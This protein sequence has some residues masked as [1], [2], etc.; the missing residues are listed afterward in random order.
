MKKILLGT[1]LLVII[2]SCSDKNKT[3][4]Q[5]KTP[6]IEKT[7]IELEDESI[8]KGGSSDTTT[9]DFVLG[10]TKQQV[11]EHC[12]KLNKKK[13]IGFYTDGKIYCPLRTENFKTL[14]SIDFYYDNE[15]KL[16]RVVEQVP[17]E[18]NEKTGENSTKANYKEE[19]LKYFRG[20]L[21]LKI[22]TNGTQPDAK[23]YWLSGDK[24][25]DYLESEK[26]FALAISKISAERKIMKFNEETE[27]K[28]LE[29]KNKK[30]QEEILRK[31]QLSN[32]QK[33][34]E[35]NIIAKLKEKAKRNWPEEYSVQEYW[36]NEQLEANH[37]MLTI[38]ND[39]RIKK[40]AQ[41]NWPLDFSVQK[42]WYDEQLEAKHRL[43]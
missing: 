37:Y 40:K 29:E 36:I 1:L 11:T 26:S 5:I 27:K 23:F 30:A 21:K 4:N 33:Q 19:I 25:F 2:I 6:I 12:K 35:E 17:Q 18:P 14:I 41:R 20:D 13:I 7:A 9:L 8:K 43:E 10:M 42:Y 31:E 3:E 22:L 16:F 32:L 24:R 28:K 38:P 15:E 39:D 34:E